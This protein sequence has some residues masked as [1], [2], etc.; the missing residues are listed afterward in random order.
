VIKLFSTIGVQSGVQGLLPACEAR[1][2]DKIEVVFATAPM[3]VKRLQ[4]GETADVMILNAAGTDAMTAEGRIL[5]GS[6]TEVASSPVAVAVKAGAPKPDIS[7]PDAF[8]KAITAAKSISYSHPAA[9]GASGIYFGK[10]IEEKGI[11]AE[12]NAKTIFPPP[13]GYCAEFLLTGQAEIAIQQK[14][15]LLHV[16]GVEIVGSLPGTLD[17][18]TRF[19]AGLGADSA[20][21]AAGRALIDL[22]RSA[23]AQR[24]LKATGLNV[25]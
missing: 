8:W 22:L 9:G 24:A 21:H 14:P 19:V 4:A 23:E 20:H 12:I 13:A 16:K 17:M 15:E 3:L 10:L 5:A 7:T 11:A 18:V 2:G 1:I 6:Q 25:P